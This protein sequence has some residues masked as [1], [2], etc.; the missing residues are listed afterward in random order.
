MA[1]SEVAAGL[2]TDPSRGLSEKE[3][4]DRLREHGPNE[5]E[6][7]E[8]PSAARIMI[9]QLTSPMILL[10]GAA[11]VLSAAL[12]DIAEAAAIAVVIVLNA[13]IGFRQEYRAERAMASLQAMA[14]PQANLLR[15]GRPAQVETREIVPGDVVLLEAGSHVPADGRLLEAHTLS[16]DESV[17]T[18]ESVAASKG[19]EPVAPDAPLAER[20]SMAYS[21]T[22]VAGGRGT[23]LVTATGRQAEFGRV[24]DLLSGAESKETPLQRRLNNLVRGLAIAAG[25]IVAVVFGLG[26]LRGEELDTLLLTAVSLAVAAIPESLPAVVT[27]TL[28]LGAQRMLRRNALIRRLYAVETLGSVSTI[29]SDKTGTLTQNRMTVVVLDMAGDRRELSDE[30]GDAAIGAGEL[31]AN[32][33]LRMLLA[34]GALCNDTGQAEDGELIGDPTETALVAVARRH[35]LDKRELESFLPR[36]G[37]VPFDSERK[38]MT[39]IHRLPEGERSIPPGLRQVFGAESL[40][41]PGG[42]VAIT[43]GALEGLLACCDSVDV[44]GEQVP[45]DEGLRER[46][47]AADEKLARN[48]VRVLGVAQRVWP[49]GGDVPEDTAIESGLTLLGLEGMIDPARTEAR[50]AIATCRE[51][52]VRAVMITGDHPLTATAIARDLGLAGEDATALTGGQLE[53]LSDDELERAARDT[54]VYARVSPEDKIR[55]V[56]VLRREGEVVAMTGDGVNDAPALTQADIGVAMGITG[57]D[58]TKDAA[59]MVL[60]DDNFATIVGAVREGRIVFDNIRKFIRNILSGNLAEVAV[61]VLGP[62]VGMPIPLLPLQI[63]W[64]NLVTDGLPAMA[65]AVEPPESDVMKRPPTPRGESLLGA[66]RGRALVTRGAALTVLVGVP[67]Y[68]LWDSGDDAWQTVLF[69]SIAFAELAGS[70]AMRSER[71]SLARIGVFGNRMLVGAVALTVALQVLLV[72]VPA[73]RDVMDLEPLAARHWL[74]VTGIALAYLAAIEADKALLRLRGRRPAARG[75]S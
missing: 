63:L 5:L 70:F 69:T 24:A 36:V 21:G 47:L 14:V 28:A 4:T 13:W 8:G 6:S 41:A 72:A 11:A 66:D 23:L 37:E 58:V 9:A 49:K 48:G 33:T 46:A 16:V 54:R 29:C 34:G 73:A 15:D 56:E 10:L 65:F 62:L 59:D 45:I 30:N 32:P 60:R 55:I 27:I 20:T 7:D 2:A 12:G 1:A 61:M 17:L 19:A 39:T 42:S 25:V 71:F 22:S 26:L 18:G 67:A 3:V 74:L 38:R 44:G 57:T 53:G 51:A 31:R 68:M 40:E 50:E 75:A 43:K 64:L 35:G 52:G